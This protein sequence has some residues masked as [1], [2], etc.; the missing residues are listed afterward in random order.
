SAARG[1]IRRE[2]A[3]FTN[4]LGDPSVSRAEA[5]GRN[6]KENAERTTLNAECALLLPSERTPLLNP[7][8][9]LTRFLQT[10]KQTGYPLRTPPVNSLPLPARLPRRVGSLLGLSQ[11]KPAALLPD[12]I[13]AVR[14]DE[15]NTV[16]IIHCAKIVSS[17][18]VSW[19]EVRLGGIP[20]E[21][22]ITQK[23]I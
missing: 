20:R 23:Q 12:S 11:V 21:N 16:S 15:M 7:R 14:P 19:I 22:V 5:Q 17:D 4:E 9:K 6:K 18:L 3:D 10:I 8:K 2:Q 13:T 1:N